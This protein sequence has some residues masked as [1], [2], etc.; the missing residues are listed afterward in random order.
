MTI[1]LLGRAAACA[2]L[3]ATCSAFAQQSDGSDETVSYFSTMGTY[4]ITDEDRTPLGEGDEGYGVRAVYGWQYPSR[5]GIGIALGTEVIETDISSFTD[6]YRHS[7]E[8]HGTYALGDR[9]GFTPYALLGG[10]GNYNDVRDVGEDDSFDVYGTAGLGFV[11]GP[12]TEKGS[13]KLRGEVRYVYDTFADEYQDYEASLGIEIP[14]FGKPE[15]VEPPPAPDPEVQVVEAELEDS[16]GDGIPDQADKC[17]GTPAGTRVDGEGCALSDV[18]QLYGVLFAFDSADLHANARRLLNPVVEIFN[19]Y[20]DLEVEVAGHTDS[21][22][23]DEYNQE[24]SQRRAESVKQYLADHGVPAG[25]VS[26][27]GYGES[28]PVATNDTEEGR[29]ENRRVEIRILN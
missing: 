12:L 15:P 18:I 16:D 8:L 7:I 11:T 21:L 2:A 24:L 22:G 17:P 26:A 3:A 1:Q 5:F 10:G 20:P 29:E 25:Q 28:E 9:T 13:V 23:S 6:F 19:R 27:V 4:A 14:L